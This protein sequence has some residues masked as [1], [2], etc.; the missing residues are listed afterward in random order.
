MVALKQRIFVGHL[1]RASPINLEFVE[2]KIFQL[3]S[4][5]AFA[6]IF[7]DFASFVLTHPEFPSYGTSLLSHQS[8][9][10]NC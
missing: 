1:E 9:Q 8:H 3:A 2:N 4:T 6:I 10:N 7:L 5:R